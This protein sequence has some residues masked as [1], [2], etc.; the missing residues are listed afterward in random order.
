[1][2]HS[3]SSHSAVARNVPY[4]RHDNRDQSG[5]TTAP[6]RDSV[7]CAWAWRR[8]RALLYLALVRPRPVGSDSSITRCSSPVAAAAARQC[9]RTAHAPIASLAAFAAAHR[10]A[11][12]G[13]P[14][15]SF[16]CVG[17]EVC[18]GRLAPLTP[19]ERG[20]MALGARPD[21]RR[22]SRRRSRS[23]WNACTR[24]RMWR[25]CC[26]ARGPDA[27]VEWAAWDHAAPA[28]TSVR[29][30]PGAVLCPQP[31][32]SRGQTGGGRPQRRCAARRGSR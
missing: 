5:P 23:R 10:Y 32:H 1:M 3:S 16:P 14:I 12:K 9:R 13:A 11:S 25:A 18:W 29:Q 4:K 15:L 31:Q 22:Q 8:C 27:C 19:S 24:K 7:Q 6:V 20:R 2:Y 26:A 30:P 17:C 21:T 28:T